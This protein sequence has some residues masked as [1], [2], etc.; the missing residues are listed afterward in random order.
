MKKIKTGFI[1]LF[2]LLT[3]FCAAFALTACTNGSDIVE[4]RVENAKVSFLCGEEF[5]TGADFKVYAE[6]KNGNVEDVTADATVRQESGMDMNVA[7]DYQITVAYG[8]KRVIYTVYVN[9]SADVLRKIDAD[10]SAVKKQYRV[11]DAPDFAGIVLTLTYEN[12]HGVR[13]TTIETSLSKF[14]VAITGADGSTATD[15]F[16][17]QGA[18]TV[19]ISKDGVKA[20]FGV[21]VSGV[22]TTTVRSALAV[23]GYYANTVTS[24]TALF[25]GA[26]AK[27]GTPHTS[28]NYEYKFGNNY[29]YFKDTYASPKQEYHCSVDAEGFFVTYLEGGTIKLSNRDDIDMMY[30]VPVFLWYNKETVYGVENALE[31]LYTHATK[32]SNA[33]LEETIDSATR[34]YSFKYTGLEF[35]DNNYDYYETEATFVLGEDNAIKTATITQDY[36]ENNSPFAGQPGYKPNFVTDSTGKTT[37]T[38]DCN[39]RLLVTFEQTTGTRVAQNQYGREMFDITSYKL[40]YNGEEL[41]DESVLECEAGNEYVLSIDQ[42]TPVTANIE[43]DYVQF[44]YEGS[45]TD[46]YD[47][48]LSNEHFSLN[49]KGNAITLTVKHGGTWTLL[50]KTKNTFK[51][52]TIDVKGK[53]P[54][55][56]M[57]PKLFNDASG[58]FYDGSERTVAKGGAVYFYGAVGTYDDP[59]QSVTINSDNAEYAEITEAEKAG[60]SC[61][62]FTASEPG[63]YQVEVVSTVNT[64]VRYTFSFTVSEHSD[65][66][67]LL[68][69][70]Y[71]VQDRGGVIYDVTFAPAAGDTVHGTVTVKCTPTDTN[72]NPLPDQAT[73]QTYDFAVDGMEIVVTH[74]SDDAIGADFAV[75]ENG[76]LVLIDMRNTRYVLNRV[77]A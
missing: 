1:L 42:I 68:T 50:F 62:K 18:Y 16:K 2:A 54:T 44:N 41:T 57:K 39:Y 7:G 40:K 14:D 30:G 69:G 31:N 71:T 46:K 35:R 72:N 9:K 28:S 32:C 65:L 17:G 20:S 15:V 38:G 13:Y 4:L 47:F 23:G 22:N 56:Q 11:G 55:D 24:G 3:L 25:R 48:W 6:Y 51:K 70:K 60:V 59:S 5:E 76:E 61:W 10:T 53:A 64:T 19:V 12:E 52:L 34:T 37:P 74:S 33:D 21:N 26:F 67:T 43:I 45:F 8:D 58:S 63:T 29:T 36:Y 49:R 66:S 77:G 73:E 27:N 75:D